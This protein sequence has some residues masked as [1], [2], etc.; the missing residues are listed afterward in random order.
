MGTSSFPTK[1]YLK[2]KFMIDG[3]NWPNLVDSNVHMA[4][5]QYKTKSTQIPL[6]FFTS[7]VLPH[8]HCFIEPSFVYNSAALWHRV[9]TV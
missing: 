4:W 7:V 9:A 2:V 8:L 3:H 5:E 1:S 6:A